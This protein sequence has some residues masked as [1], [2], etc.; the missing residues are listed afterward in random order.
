MSM[1]QAKYSLQ[2]IKTVNP[3]MQKIKAVIQRVAPS[4]ATV[5]II[6]ESG[7]GK[8]LIASALHNESGRP[9]EFVA[10]NCAAVPD[11]LWESEFFGYEAGAFTGACRKGK[12]GIIERA[13]RG[14]LFL[15]EVAEIPL[16]LQA[17]ILRV[18][19]E[20]E[21]TRVGGHQRRPVDVRVV[22][23]T[24]R[25]LAAMVEEG[26]FRGDL[27]YRLS[28]IP[29]LVPP[30]RDRPDDIL[31]LAEYFLGYYQEKRGKNFAGF[32]NRLKKFFLSYAWPGNVRELANC[33]EFAVSLG[34]GG[35][36]DLDSLPH[37]LRDAVQA[38]QERNKPE[39]YNGYNDYEEKSQILRV[40]N[41]HGWTVEGKKK[42]AREL[43]ISLAT[44]YR[45]LK[46]YNICL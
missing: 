40:L 37:P 26:T 17:K 9:G 36:I 14:T 45:R 28:V 3:A 16:P 10:V 27:Y 38:W 42:A 15:D 19:Q 20:K 25:D 21:V 41:K 6:G 34:D 11:G 7:V 39:K 46:S 44:L 24:N 30:L 31:Y 35:R 43:G 5:L 1:R 8:E 4:E 12:A 29:I 13:H 18:L 2:D 32:T 33:I 23:A 22:A